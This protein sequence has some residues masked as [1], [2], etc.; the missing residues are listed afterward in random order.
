[1]IEDYRFDVYEDDIEEEDD[2]D[3]ISTTLS[4]IQVIRD[5]SGRTI[6]R[7]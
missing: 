2:I 7:I 3:N 5:M 6:Y 4:S 1:M